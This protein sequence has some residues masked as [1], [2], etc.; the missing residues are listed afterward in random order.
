MNEDKALILKG[1]AS[2]LEKAGL[3][4]IVKPDAHT[5]FIAVSND[6]GGEMAWID[7]DDEYGIIGY[8]EYDRWDTTPITF[9]L[10]DP[11]SIRDV[12]EYSRKRWGNHV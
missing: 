10:S 5:L 6:V 9:Q 3:S 1:I 2:D 12:V 4:V 7:I 11:N 8:Y